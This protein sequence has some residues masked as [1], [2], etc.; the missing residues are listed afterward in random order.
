MS[1]NLRKLLTAVLAISVCQTGSLTVFANEIG[2]AQD[3]VAYS[4]AS[5]DGIVDVSMQQL[6]NENWNV[7]KL[8]EEPTALYEN[9]PA[10]IEIEVNGYAELSLRISYLKQIEE[11]DQVVLSV[12]DRETGQIYQSETLDAENDDVVFTN[13]PMEKIFTLSISETIGGISKDYDAIITTEYAPAAMPDN[14]SIDGIVDGD[15]IDDAT[16][17][18][19]RERTRTPEAEIITSENVEDEDAEIPTEEKERYVIPVNELPQLYQRLN[20]DKLYSVETS[21]EVSGEYVLY[22][23]FV[24]KSDDLTGYGIFTPTYRFYANEEELASRRLMAT[25]ASSDM[26]Y[27][28][29]QLEQL[30]PIEVDYLKDYYISFPR[31]SGDYFRVFKF[32]SFNDADYV[33]KTLGN[34]T[35]HA[36]YWS[37]DPSVFTETSVMNPHV[38]R[39]SN[40]NFSSHL[41]IAEGIT[42]Y[43]WVESE[44]PG[45]LAFKI[46]PIDEADDQPNSIM[47][48]EA[49]GTRSPNSTLMTK[50][51]DYQGDVDVYYVDNEN[52]TTGT[53]C[54][55][56]T[57]NFIYSRL[58][59]VVYNHYSDDSV[60]SEELDENI[61]MGGNGT[62]VVEFSHMPASKY[63][64][65][66]MMEEKLE[67]GGSYNIELLPP[68]AGDRYETE[69]G[70]NTTRRATVLANYPSPVKGLTL[71]KGDVDYFKINSG[72]SGAD[73]TVKITNAGDAY[74]YQSDSEDTFRDGNQFVK[75]YQYKLSAFEDLENGASVNGTWVGVWNTATLNNIS[76]NTD[77]YICVQRG[78][79]KNYSSGHEYTLVYQLKPKPAYSA[80]L[81][82]NVT[83][84]IQE[85]ETL[86]NLDALKDI[87]MAK[88]TCKN[89]DTVI[90]SSQA[91]SNVKLYYMNGSTKTEL[92]AAIVNGLAA[93]SYNI[94]VEFYGVAATGGTVTLNKVAT[95]AGEVIELPAVTIPNITQ[96]KAFWDWAACAQMSANLRLQ[97]EGAAASSITYAKAI[98]KVKG[99]NQMNSRGTLEETARAADY[100]YT[101]DNEESYNFVDN[102]VSEQE[103]E[104][105][106]KGELDAGKA[107]IIMLTSKTTP[108]DLTLARYLLIVGVNTGD[109][110]YKIIDPVGAK[111]LWVSQNT[112]FSGG[113]EGNND[114]E[115]TGAVV[116]FI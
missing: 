21:V 12:K 115:F 108:T 49:A 75:L 90:S 2:Q 62:G 6:E 109:H 26:K 97:R 55:R 89:G 32:T 116:E 64:I 88:L 38:V 9:F 47:E 96:A 24:K 35:T 45:T 91:R 60:I 63:F 22:K 73:L 70:N 37:Y 4:Y 82:E 113:Y 100:I 81:S 103:C 33:F 14:V 58:K 20:P 98:L 68:D 104:T 67:Y 65:A 18:V 95:V 61:Y 41:G 111:Q 114:L 84:E 66:V 92:T 52:A 3:T 48:V 87:V 43:M 29:K 79:A 30:N 59:V 46:D 44:D 83:Y 15:G 7:S 16:S 94:I 102:V 72:A 27:S 76:P 40:G 11:T 25:M 51:I 112:L 101:G 36:Y 1:N 56:L 39:N 53:F 50:S 78:S 80:T 77:V 8:A 107:V 57:N 93:G 42:I 69:N 106:C 54:V 31:P 19:V 110:T 23:G 13:V 74:N 85:S 34:K 5:D 28:Q 10:R 99:T 17:V 105:Y 86:A 71:H